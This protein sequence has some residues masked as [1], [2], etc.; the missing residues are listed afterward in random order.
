MHHVHRRLSPALVVAVIAL[1]AALAGT[2]I[3]AGEIITSPSQ[4]KQGVL[5]GGHVKNQSLS[6]FDLKDAQLKQR[7]NADATKNGAGDAIVRRAPGVSRGAY[8]VTF[9]ANVLNGAD[10]STGDTVLNEN[11]AINATAHGALR[12]LFVE[13][14][15]V[16]RPNTVVVSTAALRN[17]GG[18]AGFT[19]EDNAFDITA[20]C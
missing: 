12:Q 11:C 15:T 8:E 1:F 9:N 10:G 17:T 5:D 4:V 20:S 14:P 13:G 19:A 16:Q 2:A 3:A 7:V 6:N 18:A